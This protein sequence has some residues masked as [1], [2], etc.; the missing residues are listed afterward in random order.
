[1]DRERLPGSSG[2]GTIGAG[3]GEAHHLSDVAQVI[4]GL[5]AIPIS[6]THERHQGQVDQ[7]GTVGGQLHAAIGPQPRGRVTVHPAAS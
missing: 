5:T 4:G 7:A 6:G 3:H 1:M 2:S